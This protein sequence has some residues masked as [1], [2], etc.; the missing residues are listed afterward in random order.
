MKRLI[1]LAIVSAL[2]AGCDTN[3]RRVSELQ[4]QL[5]ETQQENQRLR[6]ELAEQERRVEDARQRADRLAE[7]GGEQRVE[8]LPRVA[9]IRLGR[10]TGGYD[11]DRDRPGHEAVRVYLE[12]ID[13]QGSAIKAAGEVTIRVLDLA[14]PQG[15]QEIAVCRYGVE[16][17][18]QHW[19]SGFINAHYV[20]ECPWTEGRV[21]AH[22]QLTVRVTFLDYLTGQQFT[23]QKAFE[24]ALPAAT[25]PA[26]TQPAGPQ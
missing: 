4:Q 7:L 2:A 20:F 17:V 19:V 15:Q 8:R 5:N 22:E 3:Y 25:Q 18:A 26:A 14:E 23:E 6:D 9:R 21:P 13:T 11:A 16:E 24:I 12:P 1:T 10:Y